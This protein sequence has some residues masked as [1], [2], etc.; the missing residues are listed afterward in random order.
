MNKCGSTDLCDK[1]TATHPLLEYPGF[2][3]EYQYWARARLGRATKHTKEAY[4][5][6][7]GSREMFGSYLDRVGGERV[8]GRRDVRLLDGSQTI[9]YDIL[10]WETR[11]QVNYTN[12]NILHSILP[13]AKIIMILRNPVDRLYSGYNYFNRYQYSGNT[14]WF[15]TPEIFHKEVVKEIGRWDT[16]MWFTKSLHNC[17][18]SSELRKA[19]GKFRCLPSVFVIGM[20]KCGSTDLCD[21]LTATH[22]LLEYPGFEKEYQYW[23]RARLG[24]ATKHTKEAYQQGYGSREMFGS[25]LD[26]VGGER[27]EGR[28]DVRLLDGSQT[29]SYDILDWETRHQ[30]NYTN[31]NILHSILP[32]A[33][34]IMI[35]RNPVDRLYS[36]YNYFNRYQYSGN[37]T[38][39][40]TPEIFHKEVVK[41][42]GRWDTCMWFTKSLHNC[43]Y[44]SELRKA[45]VNPILRLPLGVYICFVKPWLELFGSNFYLVSFDK[46]R[47]DQTGTLLEIFRFLDL[48]LPAV[49]TVK[50]IISEGKIENK[51]DSYA[52]ML[53][54]TRELL[55]E[56]YRP[57]NKMLCDLTGDTD[58]LFEN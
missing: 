40:G 28:R 24:R 33:K 21:K 34:I 32:S 41:E 58:F 42:I 5:Q 43:C 35:L 11:H 19:Q 10:D 52:P 23:A 36:G 51:G 6:G 57:Y 47:T 37:T 25:Y 39:F 38:W 16:C 4:Q 17:C 8:E 2:E 54:K 44:S 29:I 7:Y 45:Q 53:N 55:S 30:V 14:T 20:N 46:Y 9:S 50:T 26:R 12:A 27:V 15:G 3:K 56:F 31:A 1:L 13:S 49:S 22:P 18:Y 48:P